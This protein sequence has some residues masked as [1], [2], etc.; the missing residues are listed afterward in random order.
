MSLR[1]VRAMLQI[2][3]VITIVGFLWSASNSEY[4]FI[5]DLTPVLNVG[6]IYC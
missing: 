2:S 5:V 3:P 4:V 6:I 1:F